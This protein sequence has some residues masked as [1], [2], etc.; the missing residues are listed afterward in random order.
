MK[1][2]EQFKEEL[3]Q[4]Q[5][6]VFEQICIG[7]NKG[8]DK[9]IVRCLQDLGFI[10]IKDY[11]PYPT[12]EIYDQWQVWCRTF[13]FED[14]NVYWDKERQTNFYNLLSIEELDEKSKAKEVSDKF[15][16]EKT[17][18]RCRFSKKALSEK[19]LPFDFNIK[20]SV[21]ANINALATKESIALFYN[22]VRKIVRSNTN[23]ELD[24]SEI[25]LTKKFAEELIGKLVN[26]FGKNIFKDRIKIINLSEESSVFLSGNIKCQK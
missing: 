6:D 2:S 5:Q 7:N 12:K 25:T 20:I 14:D 13:D 18:T 19:N 24:F 15:N 4:E 1:Q 21:R 8:H 26:E 23:I 16:I 10:E 3:N 17:Q 11:Y 9:E 22:K